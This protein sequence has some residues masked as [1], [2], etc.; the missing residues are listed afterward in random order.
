LQSSN[1]NEI[2]DCATS[3]SLDRRYSAA[4]ATPKRFDSSDTNVSYILVQASGEAFSRHS[5]GIV[6]L[7]QKLSS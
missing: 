3:A 5:A 1:D 7:L 2:I 4:S 6:Q